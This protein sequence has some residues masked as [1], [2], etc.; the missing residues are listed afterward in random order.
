MVV[1]LFFLEETYIDVQRIERNG[2]SGSTLFGRWD[3]LADSK[4][5][6]WGSVIWR[7]TCILRCQYFVQCPKKV[8]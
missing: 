3:V 8:F 7:P 6:C 2:V 4:V 1:C 5:V